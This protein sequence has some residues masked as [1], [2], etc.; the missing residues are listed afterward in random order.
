MKPLLITLLR[1]LTFRMKPEEYDE[2]RLPHFL[3]GLGFTWAVGI[4]RNWD[5]PEAPWYATLGLPSVAYI[6]CMAAMMWLCLY[7]PS[8]QKQNYFTFLTV[9]SLTA[10]PGLVYGIPVERFL[11]PSGAQTANLAFLTLVAVWRVALFGHFAVRGCRMHVGLAAL[12]ML[13]PI[14]AIIILLVM[15]GR[16]EFVIEL[17]GGIQPERR[18]SA[19]FAANHVLSVLY[20]F[21]WPVL[22]LGVFAQLV[23]WVSL[24]LNRGEE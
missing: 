22:V 4:A 16:A 12:G 2:L 9:V 19:D 3:V 11:S 14:S 10:A 21:S 7:L 24:R 8:N 18:D 6:F 15:T 20:C 13:T 5:F 17:M 23:S 1:F